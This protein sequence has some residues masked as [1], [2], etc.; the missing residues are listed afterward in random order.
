VPDGLRIGDD[1]RVQHGL[2]LDLAC[3]LVGL[4]DDAVDRGALRPAG[5][6]AELFEHLL[7]PLDL[8]VGLF[9][10]VLKAHDK[11]TVGGVVDHFRQRFKDLLLG[12]VDVPQTMN[13]QVLHR[14]YI[15]GE[16]SPIEVSSPQ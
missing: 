7:K 13:Q 4:L 3:G 8:F 10:M 9:E 14:F 15:L 12:V 16:D 2:V 5:L 1:G 6:L 11:I